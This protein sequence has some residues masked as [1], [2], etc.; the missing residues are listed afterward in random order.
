MARHGTALFTFVA[1]Y[2]DPLAD[3]LAG[4]PAGRLLLF[5]VQLLFIRLSFRTRASRSPCRSSRCLSLLCLC[6][7]TNAGGKK[8]IERER[9][10]AGIKATAKVVE[11]ADG[12][13][14]REGA[15]LE[16]HN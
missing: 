9:G 1:F 7:E 13:N 15:A 6:R 5:V 4:W 3:W 16:K 2:I 10:G 8:K 14:K 11:G 12:G